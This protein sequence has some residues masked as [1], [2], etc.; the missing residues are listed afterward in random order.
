MP[1]AAVVGEVQV[2]RHIRSDL[3]RKTQSNAKDVKIGLIADYFV[4]GRVIFI[5][6]WD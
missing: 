1:P 6:V 3:S 5:I 4:D 2:T